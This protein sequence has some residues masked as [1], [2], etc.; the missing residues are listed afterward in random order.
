V[1]NAWASIRD[2]VSGWWDAI[3]STIG[4]AISGIPAAVQWAIGG[5]VDIGWKIVQSIKDGILGLWYDATEGV[6]ALLGDLIS[7]LGFGD[8]G[9]T[10][11]EGVKNAILNA[12][13]DFVNWLWSLFGDITPPWA[14]SMAAASGLNMVIPPGFP[15]DTFTIRA[16]SGE[17]AIITPAGQAAAANVTIYGG[18]S[19]YGVQDTQ[20][21]L[22]QLA[23]L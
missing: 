20:G 9:S 8:Y 13:D 3:T 2:G 17:H 14:N 5:L 15:N 11:I 7:W 1:S 6:S 18:L 22:A 23:A 19:L 4:D 12:W 21:L 10:V 16:T